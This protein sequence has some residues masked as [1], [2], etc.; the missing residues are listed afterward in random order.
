MHKS[1]VYKILNGIKTKTDPEYIKIGNTRT[2]HIYIYLN[3]Y[4]KK[5]NTN[6]KTQPN[7]IEH[8]KANNDNDKVRRHRIHHLKAFKLY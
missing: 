5:T 2:K 8:T 1:V 3:T 4:S 6:N 7:R